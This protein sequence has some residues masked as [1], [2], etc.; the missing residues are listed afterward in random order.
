MNH[1]LDDLTAYILFDT[2]NYNF[3]KDYFNL[4][5]DYKYPTLFS[6]ESKIMLGK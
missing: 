3:S 1:H 5:K 4:L 6:R 2:K